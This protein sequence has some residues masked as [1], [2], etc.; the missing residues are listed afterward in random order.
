M[1]RNLKE[2]NPAERGRNCAQ[3]Q[4]WRKFSRMLQGQA[5]WSLASQRV[6]SE[7][8]PLVYAQQGVQY[9]QSTHDSASGA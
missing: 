4:I 7:L 6:L 3:D 8:A 9:A 1:I 5:T 2:T